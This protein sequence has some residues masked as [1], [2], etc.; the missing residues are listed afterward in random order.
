MRG[1]AIISTV[2]AGT[3]ILSLAA[4]GGGC[5]YVFVNRVRG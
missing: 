2:V 4:C 5:S 1:K 3:M